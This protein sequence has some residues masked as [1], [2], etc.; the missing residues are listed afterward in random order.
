MPTVQSELLACSEQTICFLLPIFRCAAKAKCVLT[1]Q[2]W[3]GPFCKMGITRSQLPN[4]LL[5]IQIV[6]RHAMTKEIFFISRPLK[7]LRLDCGKQN[8]VKY[9]KSIPL[10][11]LL[12]YSTKI[13]ANSYG[14]WIPIACQAQRKGLYMH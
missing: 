8:S 14:V 11:W 4:V 9:W 5:K 3:H 2:I 1:S 13:M 7:G 10:L 6:S 12:F